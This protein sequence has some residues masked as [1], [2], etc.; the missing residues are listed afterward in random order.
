VITADTVGQA[1]DR[2][3]SKSANKGYEAAM[4]AIEI[5]DLYRKMELEQGVKGKE[6]NFSHGV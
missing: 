1:V 3:G 4:A 5:V 6:K 2:C